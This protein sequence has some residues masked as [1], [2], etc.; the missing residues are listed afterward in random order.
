[1][2]AVIRKWARTNGHDL[3]DRGRILTSVIE[4]FEKAHR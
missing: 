2:S 3:S 1:M 4:A